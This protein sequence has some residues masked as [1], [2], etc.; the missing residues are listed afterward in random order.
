MCHHHSADNLVYS[1]RNIQQPAWLS[2]ATQ[3]NSIL[4]LCNVLRQTQ[5]RRSNAIF[6]ANAV[7][8]RRDVNLQLTAAGV[9]L[10]FQ[11][12]PRK[13]RQLRRRIALRLC[14]H[15]AIKA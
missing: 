2:T 13:F 3:L 10:L 5:L 14:L 12:L 4:P 8:Q 11:P 7:I 6:V 9:N 15:K 1:Y